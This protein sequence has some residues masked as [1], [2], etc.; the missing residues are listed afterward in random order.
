MNNRM[1]VFDVSKSL[2]VYF[3]QNIGQQILVFSGHMVFHKFILE[4][5]RVLNLHWKDEE[6]KA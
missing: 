6:E 3:I 4:S 5:Y 2:G 1:Q